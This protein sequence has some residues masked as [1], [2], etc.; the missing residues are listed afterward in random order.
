MCLG[1]SLINLEL[2]GIDVLDEDDGLHE[3][4]PYQRDVRVKK[5]Q[6]LAALHAVFELLR[7]EGYC[8]TTLRE[9]AQQ[10]ARA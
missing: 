6:K 5:E 9:A 7:R 2:H 10:V 4:R 8:F 1:A 3:L